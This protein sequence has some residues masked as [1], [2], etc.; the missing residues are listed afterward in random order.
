[1]AQASL[2]FGGP[3]D[4]LFFL[5]LQGPDPQ[6][7]EPTCAAC[8]PSCID[9]RGPSAWNCTVCPPLLILSDDGR[10]LSCCGAERH[11]GDG[12]IPRECCDCSASS[13][14]Q[15]G[16]QV[17]P[18]SEDATHHVLPFFQLNAS[19]G[20]TL[21]STQLKI[22]RLKAAPPKGSPSFAFC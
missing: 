9:C 21:S 17:T 4:K 12:A 18:E 3:S 16:G 13:G 19:W 14:G 20:S 15:A 2:H 10:C 11:R 1:M 6:A 7:L 22:W 5:L 8:H